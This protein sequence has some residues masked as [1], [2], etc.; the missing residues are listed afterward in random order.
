MNQ[1]EGIGVSSEITALGRGNLDYDC[2]LEILYGFGG[3]SE[4]YHQGVRR[5][6]IC[7]ASY[8]GSTQVEQPGIL[9]VICFN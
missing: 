5:V 4:L 2:G 1:N 6:K 8:G 7:R 9:P 3:I